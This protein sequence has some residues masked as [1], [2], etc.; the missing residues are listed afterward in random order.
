MS[1]VLFDIGGTN[2]RVAVS[3][4]LKSFGEAV[5]FKTPKKFD[6]GIEEIV[7]AAKS[8]NKE[9]I[10]ACAGGI[11]GVLN[12]DKSEMVHDAKLA[13]WCEKPLVETLKKKLKTEVYLENDAAL[14]GLGEA[15]FG[16]G[17]GHEIVV[18]HTVS[19][20][21]GGAKI[22]SGEIDSYRDGFEPGH[23]I[24]DIDQTILGVE[25][26]PTLEN[27]V[28]GDAL[29]ARTG[30]KPYEIPQEDTVWDQLALYLAHGLRNTILYWSPDIIVLGGSMIVGDPRILLEDIIK[31]TNE[32]LGEDIEC[33]LIVDAKLGDEGGL[34]GAMAL[35]SQKV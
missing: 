34:Y 28:S 15:H 19:T 6:D 1:Y 31:H 8:L 26:E 23:Q 3:D 17:E 33:P 35:L 13:G 12:H 29:E 22:E 14:V 7:K 11:R 18:Y 25:V 21:V 2:T 10:R 4:D 32:V 24:L 9:P 30:V 20:G 16:A 27:L 5:K